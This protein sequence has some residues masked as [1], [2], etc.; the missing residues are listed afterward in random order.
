MTVDFWP[1][2][3]RGGRSHMGCLLPMSRRRPVALC[4]HQQGSCSS[5]IGL[6]HG[7]AES[8]AAA[9]PGLIGSSYGAGC[10]FRVGSR[11]QSSG[12][13]WRYRRV[14]PVLP[15][16]HVPAAKV[17]AVIPI[18]IK[19]PATES[20]ARELVPL[21]RE[22]EEQVIKVWRELKETYGDAPAARRR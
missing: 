18:G 15:A 21:L 14:E 7:R 1:N 8:S 4:E 5:S 19:L 9:R 13:G 2:W 6:F 3:G 20:Q 10:R 17:A 16:P 12:R 11:R 22:G